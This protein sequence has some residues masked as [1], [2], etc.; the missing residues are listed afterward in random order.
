MG[1]LPSLDGAK[2]AHCLI[3]TLHA[4]LTMVIGN[5]WES[6]CKT[7]TKIRWN[8]PPSHSSTTTTATKTTTSPN[9]PSMNSAPPF[10][11]FFPALPT[12]TFLVL[13]AV[14][15][16]A[17]VVVL[18]LLWY[19]DCSGGV[20]VGLLLMSIFLRRLCRSCDDNLWILPQAA[21]QALNVAVSSAM[22]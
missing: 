4:A 12:L 17:V 20:G 18:L 2:T 6:Q 5:L 14:S 1:D 11:C 22:R 15:D 21:R 13:C 3:K 8:I 19:D 9:Q 16:K 7:K 10:V